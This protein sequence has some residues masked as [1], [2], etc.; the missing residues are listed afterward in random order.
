MV[1]RIIT[2]KSIRGVLNYNE[3]KIA[4]AEAELLLA[5][6][7]IRDPDR[8]SFKN[9]LERFEKL[10][11]QNE[12]TRTNTVHISLNFSKDDQLDDD[13][14]KSIAFD[15]M[16]RI[17]FGDQPF[18]AYRHFD[19]PHP[20]IH[21]ATV[22][23]AD[24]GA[25][26][27]THNIGRNQSEKA[28]KEIEINYRLIKAED[29]VKETA[30]ML[31]PVNLEKVTYGKTATKAAIS[32]IVREVTGSYKFTSLPELNAVLRQFNVLADR[33]TP[34]SGMYENK[35]LV[36]NL[37]GE[38]GKK[39]GVSIKASSI[40]S[41][42][43]I[44]N[45]EKKFAPNETARKPYGQ[46]LKHLLDKAV[47]T[48]KDTAELKSQL[49]KQ[50]IRILLYENVQGNIYGL[51]FIDNA[52]RVVFNGSDLG[53]T[54]GAKTFLQR[55]PSGAATEKEQQELILPG[56]T[57]KPI[58][59]NQKNYPAHDQPVIQKLIDTAFRTRNEPNMPDPFR[60]KKKRRL[61]AG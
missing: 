49:Q 15:Y 8:L 3:N 18:L 58:P 5:A 14:L 31:R 17:G 1:A 27:E 43:T 28:R 9:K 51:T 32:A 22:N 38:D 13:L 20:H 54:Y 35:G 55:L 33:G 60:R 59:A 36:Y 52:T 11:R 12:M 6:G 48:A 42:P 56:T 4:N 53:K 7:F 10:T 16:D 41:S 23:I 30:Y 57:I 40:Y 47:T 37:L 26:I 29:Q 34:G 21:I 45:L 50:G 44:K 25:R 46:R 39:I 61:L 19:A 2:G 24:G